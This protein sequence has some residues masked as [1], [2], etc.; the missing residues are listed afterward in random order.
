ML[1][2]VAVDGVGAVGEPVPAV[3]V[4]YQSKLV[5]VA[6]SCTEEKPWQNTTGLVTPGAAGTAVTFTVITALVGLSQPAIVCDA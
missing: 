1:P 5:P 2:K 6:E 4:L 3:A